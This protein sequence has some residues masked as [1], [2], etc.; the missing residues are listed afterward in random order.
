M[1][2][3]QSIQKAVFLSTLSLRRATEAPIEQASKR[4][5]SIHALLAESDSHSNN[6]H[7]QH[8][9]F[10]PRSPC[11]ERPKPCKTKHS[12]NP[13]SIH[14]LL[15]ESDAP[16]TGLTCGGG[17][18]LSTLSLRRATP[19]QTNKWRYIPYFYPRSPCGERPPTHSKSISCK[20]N[21]YP[22]SPCGE[23]PNGGT[24]HEKSRI[25][26]I[27]ALL[28]ESD[29][30]VYKLVLGR[31]YFYPR[32]PCGERPRSWTN[33]PTNHL[34]FLSTL[35]LRRA[36]TFGKSKRLRMIFLSTLSLRR[37]TQC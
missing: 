19:I 10:Y 23:R 17:R 12:T 18:F 1:L 16:R 33:W 27:H 7:F 9:N 13:I 14:A 28:A 4:A 37:A 11:G 29:A 20:P 24:Y 8:A 15:A 30:H 32:S 26:S 31:F 22:R 3:W 21:F 2:F 36:T 25:I 6:S 34:L 35:S 5:I